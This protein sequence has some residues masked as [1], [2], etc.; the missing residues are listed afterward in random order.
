MLW[1][2][3]EKDPVAVAPRKRLFRK[4]KADCSH[5]LGANQLLK[6]GM[7]SIQ[8]L[9]VSLLLNTTLPW[10]KTKGILKGTVTW[11]ETK[12]PVYNAVITLGT[13]PPRTQQTEPQGK[14]AFFDVT[15]GKYAVRVEAPDVASATETVEVQPGQFVNLNISLGR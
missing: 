1:P 8:A 15:P 14:Y 13:E 11:A 7:L 6:P 3:E 10:K 4:E 9:K 2:V 5:A 12:V